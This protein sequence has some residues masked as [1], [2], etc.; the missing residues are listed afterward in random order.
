MGIETIL[1]AAFTGLQA[2]S[3]LMNAQSQADA[4]VKTGE[5]NMENEAK[6]VRYA[7]ARQTTSFLSSGLSLEGTPTDV[8]QETYNTGIKDIKQIGANA[9]SQSSNFIAQGRSQAIGAIAGG[10]K[11]LPSGSFGAMFDTAGSFAPDSFAY[12][13]NN[14]G[15]GNDAYNMLQQKDQRAGLY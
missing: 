8:I 5:Y 7:A 15:F 2:I 10:L 12:G 14:A 3:S 6:K 9:N 4:A 11:G 1:F 13:L